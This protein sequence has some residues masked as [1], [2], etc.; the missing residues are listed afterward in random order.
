M[1]RLFF[2]IVLSFCLFTGSSVRAEYCW[3]IG[4]EGA[5]G[6]VFLTEPQQW[7]EPKTSVVFNGKEYKISSPDDVFLFTKPGLPKIDEEVELNIGTPIY[8]EDE[9]IERSDMFKKFKSGLKEPY[10]GVEDVWKISLTW[11]SDYDG[12]YPMAGGTILKILGYKT[13]SFDNEDFLFA[14]VKIIKDG[15][16]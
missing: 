16:R 11:P 4:C 6:Y 12:D 13:F 5:V 9:I 14:K 15:I 1:K 8:E 2:L 3:M 7:S 10:I